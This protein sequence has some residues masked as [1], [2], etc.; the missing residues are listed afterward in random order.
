MPRPFTLYLLG[1]QREDFASMPGAVIESDASYYRR[2]A[3]RLQAEWF[4]HPD[5][6]HQRE[7]AFALKRWATHTRNKQALKHAEKLLE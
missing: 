3:Q 6:E 5:L 7:Y 2:Q 1:A 4:E